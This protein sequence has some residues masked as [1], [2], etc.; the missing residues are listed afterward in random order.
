MNLSD[1][2]AEKGI[3]SALIVDDVFDAVPTAADIGPENDQW[4]NVNDD[5]TPEHRARILELY[6]P[7]ADYDFDEL[8]R[9]DEYVAALWQ[10]R[11]EF[12]EVLEPLF[13]MYR[14][15]QA[16]DEHYVR[17]AQH[18]LEAL[19]LRCE[20]EG[21]H[22]QDKAQESDVIL[23]DLFFGNA[24]D[25]AALD[26]SK[27]QL[28]RALSTRADNPPLVILMSRSPRL[29]DK[30]DEFRD[31][32]GLMDSA[33]RIIKKSDL[34]ETGQLQQ[35]LERLAEN[36]EDSRKLARFFYALESGIE[37]AA[38]RTLVLLR[39]LKL[40]D[41]G[42]IQQL[43]LSA[44]GEPT[45]SYLVDVFDGVLQHEIER[46]AGIID[47]ARAL[48]DFSAESHPPP[49]VAGSAELQQLVRRL[50]TQNE[51]RL[52]LPG[53]LGARVTF[54]D[55]LR[56]PPDADPDLLRRALLV[57]LTPDNVLLVLTP[58]CDL[59]RDGVPRI[60]L[61]VG[62]LKRL[63]P[64]Q[65]SYVNDAR[66]PAL[67]IDGEPVWVKWNLKHIDTVSQSKLAGALND[68]E[69]R[70]VARLRA[71]HALELQQRVLAGLGRVGLVATLPATF[72]VD[73]E[74]YYA[75]AEGRLA[76]LEVPALSDGAVCFVGRDKDADQD[77][78]LVMTELSSDGIQEAL[79]AL[80]EDQVAARAR[81]ALRH[82][83]STMDLRRR[84]AAGI[85]L[86]GAGHERW[87]GI[88]SETGAPQLPQ[89]GLLAW[90]YRVTD[91]ALSN[92]DLKKAGIILVVRDAPGADAPGLGDAIRSGLVNPGP[93]DG[94]DPAGE[95][96]G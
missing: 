71:A 22:F 47:A 80:S 10:L 11:D 67:E 44:E 81:P 63:E 79:S 70:I 93:D 66:T 26:V 69:I 32:V 78:R 61:L 13:A 16:M 25:P 74:A 21:R 75:D 24:Q 53:S 18:K 46:E 45:G 90:N 7:A 15:N 28:R 85:N 57:D 86:K 23:I 59:Q 65:W 38:N 8:V 35:Q 87:A 68:G 94:E 72:P 30:R 34:E 84:M 89:M 19:G 4:P 77:I 82:V 92:N 60:L 31:E 95:G 42:Q 12:G 88:P 14:E 73:V 3:H 37:A 48:N 40:S 52:R 96:A 62:T 64:R 29:E 50:L 55:L 39:K 51:N 6:P 54:G 76:R 58:V 83:R 1:L 43:L 2:L 5:L 17:S 91:Q 33:F 36:A 27:A 9:D 56:M 49:Y 41:I 20:T